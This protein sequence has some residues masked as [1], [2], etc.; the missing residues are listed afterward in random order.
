MK[1]SMLYNK[2]VIVTGS[3]MGIG[4]AIAL[5]F[6][7]HGAKIVLN[8]RDARKLKETE[9][10]F[11]RQGFEVKAVKG[12]VSS[13]IDS[14]YLI[15][16]TLET[17]G[18]LDILI[19]NAGIATRGT[20]EEIVPRV[21]DALTETNFL[22]SVYVTKCALPYLR[23]RKGHIIFINSICG[24]RGMP[25]SSVYSS[26]KMAQA[27]FA[28]SLRIE[29]H[30]TGI[31]VGIAYLSFIRNSPKK[32]ILNENA[33]WTILPIRKNVRVAEPEEVASKIRIM[34]E[35]RQHR[36]V[37]TLLGK[38]T[39]ILQRFFPTFVDWIFT[40]KLKEI[41]TEFSYNSEDPADRLAKT[42]PHRPDTIKAT[43]QGDNNAKGH[44]SR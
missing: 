31:H 22:G 44:A 10:E 37:H 21:F 40:W 11:I 19:N 13:L 6:A 23:R 4:K 17:F 38:A 29:L 12:D 41:R 5:N 14:Q 43:E 9:Q 27:A 2:V 32:E 16:E 35:K 15:E 28:E 34:I 36:F 8:D 24:F 20:I 7:E 1:R 26:T 30:E 3:G 18:Q 25:Y 33:E 39:Y 42:Q